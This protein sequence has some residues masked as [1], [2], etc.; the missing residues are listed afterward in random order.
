MFSGWH[1]ARFNKIIIPPVIPT[2][3]SFQEYCSTLDY[4][5]AELLR[6]VQLQSTPEE[7]VHQLSQQ[8]FRAVS[9]GS[10][11]TNQGTFG[12]VLALPDKTRLAYGAGPVDGH[13]PKS[14]WAEGQGMLSVVCLLKQLRVWLDVDGVFTGVLAT[15]NSP[16][17]DRK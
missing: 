13:D 16:L 14:F 17:L 15:D 10:A 8:Q 2:P 3:E 12:W 4:W 11:V 5:E 9:D 6:N 7:L 1:I